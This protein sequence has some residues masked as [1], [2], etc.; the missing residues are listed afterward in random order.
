[1]NIQETKLKREADLTQVNQHIGSLRSE[2]QEK[3]ELAIRI[4]G[5]ISQLDELLEEE[6]PKKAKKGK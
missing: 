6:K 1:M 3:T 5:A 2:L 4:T